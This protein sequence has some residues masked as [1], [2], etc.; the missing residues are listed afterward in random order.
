M[1]RLQKIQTYC[2]V[3]PLLGMLFLSAG[4][5]GQHERDNPVDP[6]GVGGT[7]GGEGIQLIASLPE[8]KIQP[9]HLFK[10]RYQVTEL[11]GSEGES[12]LARGEMNLVGESARAQVLGVSPGLERTFRVDAFD[13]ANIRTF[14]ASQTL[15]VG[16]LFP[17]V[18]LFQLER[19]QGELELI[20]QLPPEIESLEVVVIAD[21]DSLNQI[22]TADETGIRRI[23][24]I[25]TGTDIPIILLGRDA[26]EQV[27]IQYQVTADI[28]DDLLARVTLSIT[29]GA[30][31]VI[32]YFPE[33]LTL[34]SVDRFSDTAGTFFRRSESPDLPGPGEP[35]DFDH[36][37]FLSR[38]FGP[39]GESILFYN[40]DVRSNVPAPVY[41]PV[42]RRGDP[43]PGQLPIFDLLPGEEGYNDLWRIYQVDIPE[44]DY[45]A[46]FL[47]SVQ[48]VTDAGYEVVPTGEVMN[49]VMVPDGSSASLRFDPAMPVAP[50]DGWY[51]GQ[52]VKFLLFENPN[53]S[54]T[55][56]FGTD[57]ISTP[58]MFAFL[59]NN[60]DLIDGFAR[61]QDGLTH[62]VVSVLPG[63]LEADYSPLW[64]LRVLK[65]DAFEQ[66]INLASA[67]LQTSE[68]S[69]EQIT[70]LKINA[71]VVATE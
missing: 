70:D 60:R 18:V 5:C 55:V 11:E 30:L 41:I 57:K 36:E 13:A 40:F 65:L 63:R 34:I 51:R 7:G 64:L 15:E 46:N 23:P 28:R 3:F 52:I 61:D 12:I 14:T 67:S 54:A 22:F 45:K 19:L 62:N 35:I 6:E 58:Q 49:C 16:L 43:I 25:P 27:L 59:E 44:L 21:G 47:T 9:E 37:R 33:Y 69:N 26:E 42:D 48:D 24:D 2:S 20:A 4:G 1:S 29:A 56:A 50:Q 31:D 32:A 10:F 66:V 68:H 38:G 39:D 8:G 71:P 53:S 17:Q